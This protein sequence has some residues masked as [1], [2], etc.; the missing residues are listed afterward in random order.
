MD[1]VEACYAS[2]GIFGEP[3]SYDV[4]EDNLRAGTL[5]IYNVVGESQ[6]VEDP[7]TVND[8]DVP[9][10]S[11]SS[12]PSECRF[13][14]SICIPSWYTV[15]RQNPRLAGLTCS[16]VWLTSINQVREF[17]K[18]SR[19]SLDR[20]LSLMNRKRS[21]FRVWYRS[22]TLR[23]SPSS[24][25][26]RSFHANLVEHSRNDGALLKHKIVLCARW[27]EIPK[28]L[29]IIAHPLKLDIEDFHNRDF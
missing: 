2:L 16:R 24:I 22:S 25:L 19:I 10:C 20:S 7:L 23:S 9:Y 15:R 28:H 3:T 17:Q 13:W 11:S 27:L 14:A 5:Q 8:R 18:L 26:K 6:L 1:C 4:H 29:S 21:T 12:K